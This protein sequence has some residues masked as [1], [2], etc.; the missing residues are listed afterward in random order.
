MAVGGDRQRD[1]EVNFK[2]LRA[3]KTKPEVLSG[4]IPPGHIPKP[5]VLPDYVAWVSIGILCQVRNIEIPS[6]LLIFLFVSKVTLA[7]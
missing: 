6:G 7:A 4:H 5:I 3:T 1:Q 2:E